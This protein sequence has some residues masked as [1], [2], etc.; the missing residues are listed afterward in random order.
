MTNSQRRE[1]FRV[2][3][4]RRLEQEK[5][6]VIQSLRTA[7][8]GADYGQN[9]G[10]ATLVTTDDLINLKV[11]TVLVELLHLKILPQ[12]LIPARHDNKTKSGLFP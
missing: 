7:K 1:N 3:V 2:W 9:T 12:K 6:A 11:E 5:N 4:M 10:T 8:G